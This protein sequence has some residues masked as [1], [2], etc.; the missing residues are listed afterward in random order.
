MDIDK[1][2][3]SF[4]T[5]DGIFNYGDSDLSMIGVAKANEGNYTPD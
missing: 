5:I 2:Y 4:M 3:S 1:N